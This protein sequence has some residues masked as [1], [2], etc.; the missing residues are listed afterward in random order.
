MRIQLPD[1]WSAK[2]Q[3]N[4]LKKVR[5]TDTGCYQW[6]GARSKGG[7][8]YAIFKPPNEKTQ[9]VHVTLWIWLYGEYDGDLDHTCRNMGCINLEH[10]DNVTRHENVVVRGTGITAKN[11]RKTH[12]SKGHEYTSENTYVW[13]NK[14][15]CR[16]CQR[17]RSYVWKAEN[18]YIQ[19]K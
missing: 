8:G 11:A 19:G 10:L 1:H 5:E 6:L 12:C 15:F 2:T 7:K 3:E 14:R 17:E 18:G 4:F 13:R 9:V 16:T